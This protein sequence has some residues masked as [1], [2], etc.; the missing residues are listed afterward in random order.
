MA[1][2]YT[3]RPGES[4]WDAI[5]NATG[6][7]VNLD[8]VLDDNGFDD[9]T[10]DLPAGTVIIISDAVA[11][12]SNALQQFGSYPVCNTSLNGVEGQIEAIFDE[13]DGTWILSTG[14]WDGN[15]VWTADGLWLTP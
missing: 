2:T 7:L 6:S 10:P 14:Y 12:D 3:I 9:W 5:I 13:L 1:S 8:Q 4:L 15:A 11:L